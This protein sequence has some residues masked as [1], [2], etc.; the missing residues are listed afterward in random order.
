MPLAW[1]SISHLCVLWV[2]ENGSLMLP[3]VSALWRPGTKEN[4]WMVSR[5]PGIHLH[6]ME[7]CLI[8]AHAHTIAKPTRKGHIIET[9]CRFS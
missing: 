1:N 7:K 3:G 6:S 4:T 8:N 5:H 9:L 2:I